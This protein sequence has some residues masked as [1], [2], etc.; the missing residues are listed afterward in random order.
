MASYSVAEAKDRLS[1]LLAA[2][3]PGEQVTITRYGKPVA[4][5]RP[6]AAKERRRMTPQ[7]VDWLL[8]QIAALNLPKMDVDNVTL[9]NEMR[10]AD[11][12]PERSDRW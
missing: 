11:V 5:L 9:I 7:D 10:E 1:A 6:V 8:Q 4:E 12:D 2:V 3:E